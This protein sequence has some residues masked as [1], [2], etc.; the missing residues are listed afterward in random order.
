MIELMIVVAIIGI[1]ASIAIPNFLKFQ[2]KAR[3]SEARANLG[4]VAVAEISY[5]AEKNNWGFAFELIGWKTEG[6]AKY[7]YTLGTD[8]VAVGAITSGN[9]CNNGTTG[10]HNNCAPD[11]SAGITTDPEKGFTAVAE[12][13]IDA[14]PETDCWY[15]ESTKSPANYRNDVMQ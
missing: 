13:N 5:F 3:Q 2:A 10:C 11:G 8:P 15:V 4:S 12:G 1:L 9:Q 7:K 14:D 6:T